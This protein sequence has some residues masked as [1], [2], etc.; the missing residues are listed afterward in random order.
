MNK[1]DLNNLI[2]LIS[3]RLAD[4]LPKIKKWSTSTADD[5][6]NNV[7]NFSDIIKS[8]V[9]RYFKEK[10]PK[11]IND[12]TEFFAKKKSIKLNRPEDIEAMKR[13][14]E[15]MEQVM[16]DSKRMQIESEISASKVYLT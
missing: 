16:R 6:G 1:Q 9:N 11:P 10:L 15:T 12:T 2:E 14:N 7:G 8:E 4:D 5:F 3:Q 13:M